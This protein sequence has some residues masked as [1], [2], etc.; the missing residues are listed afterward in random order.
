M[1]KVLHLR[2]W[3]RQGSRTGTY[4]GMGD[5]STLPDDSG[6]DP[7][8]PDDSASSDPGGLGSDPSNYFNDPD[9][10]TT[11]DPS[12]GTP[13]DYSGTSTLQDPTGTYSSTTTIDSS[14]QGTNTSYSDPSYPSPSAPSGGGGGVAPS[15]PLIPGLPA[16]PASPL[17]SVLPGTSTNMQWGI[18]G[19]VGLLGIL[20]LKKKAAAKKG[21]ARR[22]PARRRR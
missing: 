8:Q 20:A 5:I 16:L 17:A 10:G 14:G 7:L 21:G 3:G 6:S 1:A 12:S 4:G 18:L 15:A 9:P 19:A 11:L 13:I 22:A 2:R